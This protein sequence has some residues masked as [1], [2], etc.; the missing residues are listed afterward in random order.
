MPCRPFQV[1]SAWLV[2]STVLLIPSH[3]F[4]MTGPAYPCA[5]YWQAS[6][7]ETWTDVAMATTTTPEVL[8]RNNPGLISPFQKGTKVY[9]RDLCHPT[10]PSDHYVVRPG[11]TLYS[12]AK[13]HGLHVSDL[14]YHNALES[15]LL[16]IGLKLYIPPVASTLDDLR[17][18]I[19]DDELDL[20]ERLVRAEAGSEPL[21]GQIAV[22]AVVINRV[23]SPLFPSTVGGVI[24]QD[25]QFTPVANGTIN[26]PAT[27]TAKVAVA[28]ALA[29]QDPTG[30]AVFFANLR[31]AES[32]TVDMFANRL[33]AT[34]VIG[35]HTFAV[36]KE[37]GRN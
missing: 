24:M 36:P 21:E 9:V 1:W 25:G 12:I 3:G 14:K 37:Q 19:T 26:M 7:G 17:Q 10:E 5:L 8:Q 11:D 28:R 13:S 6:G 15:D 18:T 2:A 33:E 4:G 23:L 27:A 32:A 30:G 34:V 35:E 31:L 20:L 16:P 22:A 29:G